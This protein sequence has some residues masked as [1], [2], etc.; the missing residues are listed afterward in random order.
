MDSPA[1][2]FVLKVDGD[3]MIGAGIFPNDMIVVDKSKEIR[4]GDVVVATLDGEF[5]LKRYIIKDNTYIFLQPENPK[6][7]AIEINEDNDFEVWGLVTCVL[8]NPNLH[9]KN[10]ILG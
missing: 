10:D 7:N 9:R 8:H 6:Y 3:S 2:S 1:S 5:T 4:N